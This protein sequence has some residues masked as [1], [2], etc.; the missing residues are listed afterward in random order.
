MFS[1][2]FVFVLT[3]T[4][5]KSLGS[6]NEMDTT[7]KGFRIWDCHP[8]MHSLMYHTFSNLLFADFHGKYSHVKILYNRLFVY[9]GV[10][11]QFTG[12]LENAL[13]WSSYMV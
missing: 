13:N 3:V 9:L 7:Y 2:P 6:A 11:H 1:Q 8:I 4:T 5:L 12:S 10:S